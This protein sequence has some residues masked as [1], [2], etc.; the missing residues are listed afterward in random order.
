[1]PAAGHAPWG[2]AQTA[3]TAASNA[4]ASA[5]DIAAARNAFYDLSVTTLHTVRLFRAS[6]NTPVFVYHCPMAMDGAGADWLQLKEG[7][8]N[9]Y[10][11]SQMFKCGS[12][13][14]TLIAGADAET[15]TGSGHDQH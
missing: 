11:S 2:N 13:T 10:Y 12:Q 3:L 4:I 14:E 6:G 5:A 7:T 9:P 1:L 15:Q 8:E